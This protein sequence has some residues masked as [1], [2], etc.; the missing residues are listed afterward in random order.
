ML[1]RNFLKNAGAMVMAESIM[2]SHVLHAQQTAG[3]LRAYV[4]TYTTPTDGNGNGEGIYLFDVDTQS[5]ELVN[6]RL[7]EW[8]A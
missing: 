6:R 1:R 8:W 2:G 4:G 5:G 3:K 7:V